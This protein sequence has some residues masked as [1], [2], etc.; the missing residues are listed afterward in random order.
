[1]PQT[2]N[3]AFENL[4]DRDSINEDI[5]INPIDTLGAV[6]MLLVDGYN[7]CAC[8][9]INGCTFREFRRE[10]PTW[11][12]DLYDST[13]TLS[14][15]NFY[16]STSAGKHIL[17]GVVLP[18]GDSAYLCYDIP[19]PDSGGGYKAPS[20]LQLIVASSARS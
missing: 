2:A 20:D 1:M 17:R 10:M 8:R 15:T 18:P 9:Y 3:G 12:W 4:G 13:N 19:V 14:M 16:K 5:C 11:A 6:T 7:P